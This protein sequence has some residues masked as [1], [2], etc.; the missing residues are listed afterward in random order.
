MIDALQNSL[1]NWDGK[2]TAP[3][4]EVFFDYHE[5]PGFLVSLVEFC[6]KAEFQRGA[7]W[8][9]K[10]HFDQKRPPLPDELNRIHLSSLPMLQHWEAKLH[11]LQYLDRLEICDAQRATVCTFVETETTNENKFVRA[12][13]FYSLAT[14]ANRFPD[15]RGKALNTL[16]AAALH[17]TASSVKV[18]IR[19]ALEK[20]NN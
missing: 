4:E 19:K 16:Q 14:L 5:H 12:W 7:T 18:R 1:N 20:L 13:A 6:K 2:S 9:L 11:M 3:L 8:L 17:E 10:H 15:L